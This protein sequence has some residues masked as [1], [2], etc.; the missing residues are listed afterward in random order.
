VHPPPSSVA[1]PDDAVNALPSRTVRPII[2]RLGLRHDDTAEVEERRAR[3]VAVRAVVQ[4]RGDGE[5]GDE[6]LRRVQRDLDST[7]SGAR[8]RPGH[9]AAQ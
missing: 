1:E 9:R 8:A 6:A 3:R 4:L 2:R 7:T 5:I